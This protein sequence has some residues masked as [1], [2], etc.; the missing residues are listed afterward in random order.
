MRENGH[1]A[2]LLLAETHFGT[3]EVM[4]VVGKVLKACL[5]HLPFSEISKK[6]M[7]DGV[8]KMS[9]RVL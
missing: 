4:G 7:D 6:M 1:R 9:L 5:E 2:M 3:E 8:G